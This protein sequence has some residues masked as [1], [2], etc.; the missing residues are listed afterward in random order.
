[1]NI[2]HYKDKLLAEQKTLLEELSNIGRRRGDNGEWEGVPENAG[3]DT[4]EDVAEKFEELEERRATEHTLEVRLGE[5]ETALKKIEIGIYGKC[6]I[7]G[8]PIEEDRLEAN[9][10]A[11]TC[12]AHL[13]DLSDR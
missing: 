8:E 3:N 13:N 7:S 10:A 2:D 6:E 12:K 9:P 4:R 5:V 11:R 1:M